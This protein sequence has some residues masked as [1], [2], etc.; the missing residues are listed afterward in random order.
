[1]GPKMAKVEKVDQRNIESKDGEST[2]NQYVEPR[3]LAMFLLTPEG[4]DKKM[5]A[6]SSGR[7]RAF[8]D[9]SII[10]SPAGMCQPYKVDAR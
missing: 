3:T 10:A 4:Q 2:F 6:T 7:R 5:T 1:M 8:I 9:S